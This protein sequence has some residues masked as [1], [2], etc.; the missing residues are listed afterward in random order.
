MS[1]MKLM[2]IYIDNNRK[3]C[4]W[5]KNSIIKFTKTNFQSKIIKNNIK[6]E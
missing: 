6:N 3:E 2:Q 1:M 4:Q 5:K